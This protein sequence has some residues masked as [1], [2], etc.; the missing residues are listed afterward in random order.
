MDRHDDP[1]GLLKIGVF[2]KLSAI[3]VRMLRHYQ[4]QGILLPASVDPFTGHRYY[5]PEQL[6]DARWVTLM[7]DAGLPVADIATALDHRDDPAQLRGLLDAHRARLGEDRARLENRESAFD[8]ISTY[9]RSSAMTIT[10]RQETLPAMTVAS[11]RRVLPG[12]EDEGKLWGEIGGLMGRSGAR[13]PDHHEGIGGATFWDPEYRESDVDV[14]IWLT[15]DGPFQPTAPL[16]CRQIPAQEIVVATMN[17][18]YE[19]MP[20][21][22]EAIGAYIAGHGLT[23]GP[24]FNIYRVGPAQDPNPENWVTDV[25]FPIVT[26]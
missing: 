22:T 9:L 25:C 23:T 3:S 24:M 2:S 6:V 8:R 5:R 7:R 14:E 17:G 4:E 12:Y 1:E 13:M 19:Q 15:V 10:V 18:S 20:A 21:I 26:R 11:L 16:V